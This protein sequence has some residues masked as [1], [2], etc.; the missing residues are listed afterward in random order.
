MHEVERVR[1]RVRVFFVITCYGTQPRRWDSC[2]EYG[3]LR[4]DQ[5]LGHDHLPS[6][7]HLNLLQH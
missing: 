3:M 4:I 7:L 5:L 6:N 2:V 1:V